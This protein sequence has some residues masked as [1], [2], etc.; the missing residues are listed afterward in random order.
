MKIKV[1]ERASELRVE[2]CNKWFI[3][4]IKYSRSF[5]LE[6]NQYIVCNES[7]IFILEMLLKLKPSIC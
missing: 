2:W 5:S 1:I 3:H 6:L 4:I 7:L